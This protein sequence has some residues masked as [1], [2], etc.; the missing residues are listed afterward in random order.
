ML[1]HALREDVRV[2]S[3]TI[4]NMEVYLLKELNVR[5]TKRMN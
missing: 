5:K 3:F 4:R 1:A 2:H